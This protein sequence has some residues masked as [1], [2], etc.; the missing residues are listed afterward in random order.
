LKIVNIISESFQ[1][2][3]DHCSIVLFSYGCNLRCKFCYNYDFVSDE[4]NIINKSVEELIDEAYNPMIDGLVF[5]GGEPTLYPKKIHEVSMYVKSKYD[6]S[7]KLYTNG[8]NPL[9]VMRGLREGWLDSVSI[10]FKCI[11]DID[12]LGPKINIENTFSM[13]DYFGTI[14]LLLRAINKY[15]VND[16]VEIRTTLYKGMPEEDLN[17]IKEICNKYKLKHIIQK[18]ITSFNYPSA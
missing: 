10:D 9:I 15:K 6:L 2:Y 7:T 8:K 5:L 1:E 14:H 3:E 11:S 12:I 17:K 18:E 16:K 13:R 4:N